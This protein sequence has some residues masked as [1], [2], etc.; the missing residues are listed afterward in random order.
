MQSKHKHVVIPSYYG[1][2]G[3]SHQAEQP[4]SL[5]HSWGN[6]AARQITTNPLCLSYCNETHF[7]FPFFVKVCLSW[8]WR[9]SSTYRNTKRIMTTALRMMMAIAPIIHRVIGPEW[10][11]GTQTWRLVSYTKVQTSI[12]IMK[13][14]YQN[15]SLKEKTEL[16]FY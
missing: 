14:V 3:N 16:H 1:Y 8:V 5:F 12:A 7:I 15:Y 6:R 13:V 4:M 10:N 11:D 2:Y 9:F